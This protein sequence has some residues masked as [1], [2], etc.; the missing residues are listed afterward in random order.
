MEKRSEITPAMIQEALPNTWSRRL[1]IDEIQQ[2][3]PLSVKS[4]ICVEESP[5]WG[6]R[7]ASTLIG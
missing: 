2:S 4:K 5:P 6:N 7:F 3:W 1:E